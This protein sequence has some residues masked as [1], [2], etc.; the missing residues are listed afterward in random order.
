[1]SETS[2]TTPDPTPSSLVSE[3]PQN[4]EPPKPESSPSSDP[5]KTNE[6]AKSEPLALE[7]LTI[8]EGFTL[9]TNF[10]PKFLELA[11]EL[12]LD[13]AGANKL[14]ALQAELSR[15]G[16]EAAT[17]A[18]EGTQ[19]QWQDEVR[20]DTTLGGQNLDGVLSN[21]AALIDAYVPDEKG[22]QE[23]R[24]VFT[25][26]GAGNNI[27]VIRFLHAIAKERNESGPLSGRPTESGPRDAASILYP[28]Q[29]KA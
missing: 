5:T 19:K 25:L 20:A 1:M 24:Q 22:R 4:N 16:S 18:W 7:A 9:D 11:N 3:S 26:T 10:A 15:K 12:K 28:N 21:V 17:Q 23:L 8:P 2:T 13:A 29:G 6:P 27:H 14:V